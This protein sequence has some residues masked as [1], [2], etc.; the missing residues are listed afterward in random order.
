MTPI[1]APS[2][3]RRLTGFPRAAV[4]KMLYNEPGLL[5]SVVSGTASLGPGA[6]FMRDI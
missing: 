5:H 6:E 3:P 2:P 4:L 1:H